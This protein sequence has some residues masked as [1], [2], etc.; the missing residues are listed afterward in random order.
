V[1]VDDVIIVQ[2]DLT[3]RLLHAAAERRGAAR[4]HAYLGGEGVL[5]LHGP[6]DVGEGRPREVRDGLEPREE[7]GPRHPLEVPLRQVQKD[8]P[9][10]ELVLELRDEDVVADD[11]P[12]VLFLHL[13]EDLREPLELL[14]AARHP[15]EQHPL[16]LGAE[17]GLRAL[18]GDVLEDGGEGSHADAAPHQHGHFVVPP[19][20]V[21]LAVRP[22]H[23]DHRV[24]VSPRDGLEVSV[25]LAQ[26]QCPR[27]HCADVEGEMVLVWSRRQCE[28]VVL[29]AA[30]GSRGDPDP[31]ACLEAEVEGAADL[32]QRHSGR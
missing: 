29:L 6:E 22:V 19:R 23:V 5:P 31:L 9:E 24:V 32:E 1:P 12:R 25:L 7:R 2:V 11:A 10:V 8:C 17:G 26:T 3:A 18:M 27:A 13:V 14:L 28:R 16:G 15:Q 20:L 21:A 4:E 30:D